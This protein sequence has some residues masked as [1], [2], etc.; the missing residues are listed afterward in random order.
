MKIKY[1][2]LYFQTK[3]YTEVWGSPIGTQTKW[4]VVSKVDGNP[5]TI[6]IRDATRLK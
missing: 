6:T 3:V 2:K 4:K 5:I 1:F